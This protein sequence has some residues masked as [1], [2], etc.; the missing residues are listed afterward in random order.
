V[1]V[2]LV[3]LP[4]MFELERV[5][6]WDQIE[7]HMRDVVQSDPEA[8]GQLLL[9]LMPKLEEI[10]RKQPIGRLN[11]D[12]DVRRDILVSV[13]AKLHSGEYRAIKKYLA[14]DNPPPIRIWLRV[15]ARSA[16]IDVMRRHPEFSPGNK[17]RLPRWFSLATL[18]SGHGIVVPDTLL[19]K[20]R[21][22]ELFL[23]H[24][25][26]ES[27]EA[28]A[29]HGENAAMALAQTWNIK[30]LHTRRLIKRIDSFEETFQLSLAGHTYGEIAEK[31]S[32]SR[33]EVELTV[34][35]LEEFFQARGF[36]TS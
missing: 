35:Y 23:K 25:M 28:M 29:N 17:E 9:A 11:R 33:R 36:S 3:Q 14:R 20:K 21:E 19:A 2:V 26:Q 4:A 15:L 1:L 22:A 7:Q 10:T 16:A 27:R 5:E 30:P 8:W 6:V 32:R 34:G 12:E 18:I 31:M 24:T 13:I